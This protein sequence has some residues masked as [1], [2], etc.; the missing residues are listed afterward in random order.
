MCQIT[1]ENV[2]R[3]RQNCRVNINWHSVRKY[4]MEYFGFYSEERDGPLPPLPTKDE[5]PD[6]VFTVLAQIVLDFLSTL[7][8]SRLVSLLVWGV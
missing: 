5:A 7:F 4:L 6:P 8:M 3:N 1:G 2:A